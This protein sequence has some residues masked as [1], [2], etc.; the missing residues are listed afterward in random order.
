LQCKTQNYC[1][2]GD[3]KQDKE[4]TLGYQTGR[5]F[6]RRAF[7]R[8]AKSTVDNNSKPDETFHM[9]KF[10]C[11][12]FLLTATPCLAANT[13]VYTDFDISKCL[14]IDP[15]NEDQ[16][17]GGSVL[18]DGY[19]GLKVFWAGG[20]DRDYLAYGSNP[21]QHCSRWQ[22]FGGF[23][24]ANEKI[25]WRLKQGKPI[26]VIHRWTVAHDENNDGVLQNKTWLAVTKLEAANSCRMADVEGALPGANEK[27]RILADT[28]TASFKCAT[29]ASI[30]VSIDGEK[31][32]SDPCPQR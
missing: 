5:H 1:C 18:C 22:T 14:E 11:T 16:N 7:I 32:S 20:D 19:G 9:L 21:E 12:L 17:D 13:S 30:N 29:S 23:N 28:M 27:A 10:C 26:A 6:F 3:A 8:G 15:P 2:Q 24:S 31:I 25:E 4:S